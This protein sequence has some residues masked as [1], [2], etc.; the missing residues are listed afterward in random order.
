MGKRERERDSFVKSALPRFTTFLSSGISATCHY[1]NVRV[2]QFKIRINKKGRGGGEEI[3]NLY[4]SH[5]PRMMDSL[6]LSLFSFIFR[7]PSSESSRFDF[8]Q[9]LIEESTTSGPGRCWG[10]SNRSCDSSYITNEREG[11][12]ERGGR[13]H[14]QRVSQSEAFTDGKLADGQGGRARWRSS[15]GVHSG[16]EKFVQPLNGLLVRVRSF[17]KVGREQSP[18]RVRS[19]VIEKMSG[20]MLATPHKRRRSLPRYVRSEN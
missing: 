19:N 4:L 14:M 15:Y 10:R 12:R 9:F 1:L 3:R 11:E 17:A 13:A 8:R 5:I 6:S 18:P 2:L 20:F 7:I 16:S